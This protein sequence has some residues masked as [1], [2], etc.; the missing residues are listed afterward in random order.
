MNA[1]VKLPDHAVVA[2][3][4]RWDAET[5]VPVGRLAM[6]N[7]RP[8]FEYDPACVAR[9]ID[10]SPFT[11]PR[12]LGPWQSAEAIFEGLP[13]VLADSLPDGWGRLLLD[14]HARRHGVAP[15]TLTP[16]DR[17]AHVG[18][19]GIGA[20]VYEP[21]LPASDDGAALDLDRLA[22]AS[23]DVLAN[24]GDDALDRLR[25]LGG[26]P[27]GARPKVLLWRHGADGR[28]AAAAPTDAALWQA[29]LVKFA[30][31]DDPADIGA[32]ELA[33]NRMAAAAGVAVPASRLLPSGT[34][35]GYFCAQ[36]FDRE[37]S[38]R[39]HTATASALLHADHRLPSLDYTSLCQLALRL[40][41]DTRQLLAMFRLA[42]FN[43][44]AH[45]RDDHA[46]Q[47]TFLADRGGQWCL[48]PAYD[49]T[50]SYGPAGEHSTSVAGESRAPVWRHLLQVA[51]AVGIGP[52]DAEGV[53]E[54][55]RRA[56]ADWPSLAAAAGV[57][58]HSAD[59][60]G[61][62]LRKLDSAVAGRG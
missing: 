55:T 36:R 62:A 35:A 45:N 24:G 20:L 57:T 61:K 2:V 58:E 5:Q 15:Q 8:V 13:G 31:A 3:A 1:C 51:R 54:Q 7:R 60:I 28:L 49:L 53:F 52:S 39:I 16:L 4:L 48:S 18:D 42:C 30:S 6:V 9:G 33:Y 26:S 43:V 44:L 50:F 56:V 21:Q 34:A 17:L 46:R 10:L 23:A 19:L 40:C 25:R 59:R 22:A 11:L 47:F 29:C 32:I 38:R 12:Q 37:G 14:R 27:H 41:R